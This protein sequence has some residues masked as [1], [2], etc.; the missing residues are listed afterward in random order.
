MLIY[1]IFFDECKKRGK[2]SWK[3]PPICSSDL[4]ECDIISVKRGELYL[5]LI[6]LDLSRSTGDVEEPKLILNSILLSKV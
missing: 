1:Y 4:G 2:V 3:N 6:E 5:K